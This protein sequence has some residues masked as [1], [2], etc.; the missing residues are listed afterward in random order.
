[1]EFHVPSSLYLPLLSRHLHW[2]NDYGDGQM[3][4]GRFGIS[5]IIFLNS[6]LSRKSTSSRTDCKKPHRMDLTAFYIKTRYI[7]NCPSLSN[8]ECVRRANL[9][10]PFNHNWRF[11]VSIH[12]VD[13]I[14]ELPQTVGFLLLWMTDISIRFQYYFFTLNF[15]S[16]L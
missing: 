1:M 5:V 4:D 2:V 15:C 11:Y 12:K 3:L 14:L 13:G 8:N 10:V 9:Q 7:L 16:Y 6:S